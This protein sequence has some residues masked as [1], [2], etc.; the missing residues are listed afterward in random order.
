[1]RKIVSFTIGVFV[2][3]SLVGLAAPAFAFTSGSTG[4]EDLIVTASQS[5]PL[6][7]DG[8]LQY[9]NVHIQSG[10]ELTF[11]KNEK[12]T[13]VTILASGDVTID[14]TININ[15]GKGAYIQPG[16]GG[17]GGFD[18]GQGGVVGKVGFRGEGPG[19]GYG[20][21]GHST[22]GHKY[23]GACGGGGGYVASGSVGS[24]M[25]WNGN[26]KGGAGGS[27]YGNERL[28]PLIGGSGGGGGGGSASYTAGGGGGGGGAILIAASGSINI[29]GGIYANGGYGK[30]GEFN[31]NTN[32]NTG[33]SG[34]GG[35]GGAIRLV[36]TT[37]MGSGT[38]SADGKK[39]DKAYDRIY[40]GEGSAGRIRLE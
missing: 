32:G 3:L 13:P 39:S 4:T 10:A 14:G 1:M 31:Y 37:I 33:G 20:A 27:K 6:P 25:I 29:T 15:G 22:S 17:P 30:A 23:S 26:I 36:A 21:M 34:G 8:V 5:I 9:A 19:G 35:A 11:T 38:L 16:K 7:P 12:N 2:L 40:G 24:N 18:G 28:I